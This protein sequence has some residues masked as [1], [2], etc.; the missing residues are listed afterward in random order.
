MKKEITIMSVSLIAAVASNGVIGNELNEMPWEPILEDLKNF[1][2]ITTG[3][4]IV[5]GAR[6]FES[7]NCIPLPNRV[8][9]VF[10]RRI[11]PEYPRKGVVYFNN[12]SDF[13]KAY[14]VV[15]DDIF[16][17]GGSNIFKMF[18]P[19][20]DSMYLTEIKKAYIGNIKFPTI[21]KK[22]WNKEVL[23]TSKQGDI[24]FDFTEY[25]RG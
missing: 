16:I 23:A 25:T 10:T 8:N 24:E 18:M 1:R 15:K 6:T 19:I 12:E 17:I 14:D 21:N 4:I 2:D 3:N 5:M 20:A 13:L 7:I 22:E 9:V 11:K